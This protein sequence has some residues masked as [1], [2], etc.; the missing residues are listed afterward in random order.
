MHLQMAKSVEKFTYSVTVQMF[1]LH[2]K[3]TV[4]ISLHWTRKL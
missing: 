3:A 4:R 2:S 1:S